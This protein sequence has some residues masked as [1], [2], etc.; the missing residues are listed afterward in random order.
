MPSK[1]VEE[2]LREKK[3][4]EIVNP[5]LVQASPDISVSCAIQIM[6]ENKA[7]YIILSRNRKTVG[8]FTE[9]DV[10]RKVLGTNADWNKPVSEFMT[11]TPAVLRLDDS[12]G[13][14][15]DTMGERYFYHVPLVSESGEL[16]NVISVRTLIRFLAEFYPKEIY[17]L[18]PHPGQVMRTPEGG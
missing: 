14:A 2:L 7:G 1:S 11:S 15:I 5:R 10:V 6:Q 4:S 8:I 13:K 9:T 17:N 12:I 16:V 3:I 18:P